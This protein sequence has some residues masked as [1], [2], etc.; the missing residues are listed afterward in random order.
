MQESKKLVQESISGG[1][2]WNR[3]SMPVKENLLLHCCSI[4][5]FHDSQNQAKQQNK[6]TERDK[7][8][9]LKS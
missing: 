4:P 7:K 2:I 1:K 6:Q 9:Y 8:M 5:E 3:K